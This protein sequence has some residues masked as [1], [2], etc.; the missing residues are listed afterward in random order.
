[1]DG[2]CP[3]AT[4]EIP[5]HGRDARDDA[6][7]VTL[8][9][10]SMVRVA[11]DPGIMPTSDIRHGRRHMSQWDHAE[12]DAQRGWALL[13]YRNIMA[14]PGD[15]SPPRNAQLHAARVRWQRAVA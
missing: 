7:D 15:G 12:I 10:R 8:T 14:D 2:G 5:R 4:R 11:E 6:G 13:E 3:A 1:M 9:L